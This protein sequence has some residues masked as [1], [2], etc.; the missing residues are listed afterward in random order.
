MIITS[1]TVALVSPKSDYVF[2]EADWNEYSPKLVEE[3]GKDA[4]PRHLYFASKALAE[5]AA[6]KFVEDHSERTWDLVTVL[7]PWVFGVSRSSFSHGSYL[8]A[9]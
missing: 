5:R 2:T 8:G 3:Q 1:S 4:G 7:P 6:W 9:N